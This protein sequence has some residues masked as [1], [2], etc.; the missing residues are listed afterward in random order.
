M[1][2]SWGQKKAETAAKDTGSEENRDSCKEAG[3][4]RKQRQLQKIRGQKKT[5]TAAKHTGSEEIRDNCKRAGVRRKQSQVQTVLCL[6]PAHQAV[7]NLFQYTS[8]DTG[9]DE[10]LVAHSTTQFR[11]TLY[12]VIKVLVYYLSYKAMFIVQSSVQR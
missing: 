4:R 11:K 1:Q 6:L 10:Y 7:K 3:V 2:K 9:V 5:E 12:T 8:V